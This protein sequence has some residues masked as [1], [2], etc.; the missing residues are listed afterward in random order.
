MSVGCVNSFPV[1]MAH[2]RH[3]YLLHYSCFH[4][5]RIVGVAQVMDSSPADIRGDADFSPDVFDVDAVL[6]ADPAREH[7][8]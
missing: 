7:E 1:R 3:A 2:E 5:A 8:R 4:E 6:T